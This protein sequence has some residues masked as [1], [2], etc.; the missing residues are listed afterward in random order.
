MKLR[1]LDRSLFSWYTICKVIKNIMGNIT[2]RSNSQICL[3]F[4]KKEEKL[5]EALNNMC[6]QQ[7]YTRSGWLKQKI[8]EEIAKN[9]NSK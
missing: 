9:D 5:L 6:E 8:R 3:S 1:D 4:G 7:G 2:N